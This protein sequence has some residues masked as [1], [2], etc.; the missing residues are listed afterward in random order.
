M[1]WMRE[2]LGLVLVALGLYV[3]FVAMQLLLLEGPRLLEAPGFIAI[4][5]FIFRGGLQ[6]LKVGVA[7]RIC[8]EAQKAAQQGDAEPRR[9]RRPHAD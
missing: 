4:G 9:T 1:F 3:F 7:G 5:F 6:L 8:L 2:V